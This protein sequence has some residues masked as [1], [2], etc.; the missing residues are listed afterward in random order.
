MKKKYVLIITV[1]LVILTFLTG[2]EFNS[3]KLLNK[4]NNDS[5]VQRNQ[6]TEYT[7]EQLEQMALDYYEAKTGYRPSCVAS[8]EN[9]DGTISIQ[10][11]DSFDGHNSTSDWYTVNKKTAIGTDI[12]GNKIEL[13][14]VPKDEVSAN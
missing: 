14:K 3:K 5:S 4:E 12:L 2:C 13:N 8:Q 11:Y 1:L 9:E 7:S 10:L 6:N